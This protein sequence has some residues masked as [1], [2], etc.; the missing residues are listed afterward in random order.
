M[1]VA[2]L[3]LEVRALVEHRKGEAFDVRPHSGWFISRRA[4]RAGQA[5]EPRKKE[6]IK[7]ILL[8]LMGSRVSRGT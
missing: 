7:A 6:I 3:V 8:P 1:A 4:R 2:E 5:Y